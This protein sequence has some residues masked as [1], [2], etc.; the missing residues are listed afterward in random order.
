MGGE[1]R[2]RG[3]TKESTANQRRG[4]QTTTTTTKSRSF[5]RQRGS[6]MGTSVAKSNDDCNDA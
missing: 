3:G 6:M 5:L 2:A 1:G 4:D